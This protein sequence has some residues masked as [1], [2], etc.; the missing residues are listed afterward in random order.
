MAKDNSQ[1]QCYRHNHHCNNHVLFQKV[2]QRETASQI[3]AGHPR[4]RNLFEKKFTQSQTWDGA[5]IFTYGSSF[6]KKMTNNNSYQIIV[7]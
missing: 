4:E 7:R 3:F 1:A 5:K 2:V 6:G